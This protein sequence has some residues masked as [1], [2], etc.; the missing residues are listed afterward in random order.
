MIHWVKCHWQTDACIECTNQIY[1][2]GDHFL[3]DVAMKVCCE[4]LSVILPLNRQGLLLA[5]VQER[6]E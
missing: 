5:D 1:N 3:A 2:K 4:G 6:E